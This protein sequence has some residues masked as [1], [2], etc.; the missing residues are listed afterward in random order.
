MPS[1]RREGPKPAAA[2][3]NAARS[4]SRRLA[5][6][7]HFDLDREDRDCVHDAPPLAP[8]VA[9][10]FASRTKPA[11]RAPR[12]RTTESP[13]VGDGSGG[14]SARCTPSAARLDGSRAGHWRRWT[15]RA[16]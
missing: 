13:D 6:G 2:S 10:G 5:S 3:P 15:H 9:L 7:R 8:V 1:E 14:R 12:E 16:R 4:R 11:Q